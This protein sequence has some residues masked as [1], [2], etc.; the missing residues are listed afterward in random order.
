[1]ISHKKFCFTLA[2]LM[3]CSTSV[4]LE[5]W[6]WQNSR[7]AHSEND[8]GDGWI[9]TLYTKMDA[10]DDVAIEKMIRGAGGKWRGKWFEDTAYK[11]KYSPLWHALYCVLDAREN[12]ED[13]KNPDTYQ[14]RLT[15]LGHIAQD[16]FYEI[17]LEGRSCSLHSWLCCC[18]CGCRCTSV[19]MGPLHKAAQE[20]HI[21]AMRILLDSGFNVNQEEFLDE[22]SLKCYVAWSP[23]MAAAAAGKREAVVWLLAKGAHANFYAGDLA[24]AHSVAANKDI[25]ALLRAAIQRQGERTKLD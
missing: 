2:F 15:I 8:V 18:C 12:K 19:S 24:S 6:C 5:A 20:G 25:R 16:K 4:T 1:M 7:A 3:V 21:D 9:K 23:L 17:E 13:E 11:P 10:A 14:R 22:I